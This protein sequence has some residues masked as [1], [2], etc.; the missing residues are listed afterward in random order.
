M[1]LLCSTRVLYTYKPCVNVVLYRQIQK[2]LSQTYV[3]DKF[4]LLPTALFVQVEQSVH[5][6]GCL[7]V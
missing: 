2:K 1:N 4:S 5:R 7:C 3:C 6:L